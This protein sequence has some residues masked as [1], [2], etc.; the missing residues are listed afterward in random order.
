MELSVI[1]QLVAKHLS[2]TDPALLPAESDAS[3]PRRRTT[4]LGQPCSDR[5]RCLIDH[6]I[7]ALQKIEGR[8]RTDM[9]TREEL[10]VLRGARRP[11]LLEPDCPRLEIDLHR[12]VLFVIDRVE[13]TPRIGSVRN[14]KHATVTFLSG[15]VQY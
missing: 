10:E 9:L 13:A 7:T 6:A 1:S 5:E 15:P 4:L 2:E 14:I 11:Q 3:K 8:E 12:Q